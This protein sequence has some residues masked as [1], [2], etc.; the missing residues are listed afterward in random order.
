[1]DPE[2]DRSAG[3]RVRVALEEEIEEN[4]QVIARSDL[5]AL[6]AR[7]RTLLPEEYRDSYE[8]VQ[9]TPMRSAGLKY[10][11]DGQ[12]AWDQIWGGFCDLA[13]AGG[14]PHKGALLEPGTAAEIDAQFSRYD[15]VAEEICR[16]IRMATGLRAYV[17]PDPGW[18]C[19]T[20]HGDAMAGWLMRAI[21][22]ENVAARRRGSILELPAA[23]HFRLD[24]EIKNVITV[25]A[26]TSHYWLGHV[27]DEQQRA[28]GDLFNTMAGESPLIE[29]DPSSERAATRATAATTMAA[30][31]HGSTGLAQSNRRY[32]G[33]LG[34]E[35][36][37]VRLAIW[38]MRALVATNVLSRREGTVLFVP[39][40]PAT[41]PRGAIVA[42]AVARVYASEKSRR[43][44]RPSAPPRR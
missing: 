23:P 16:G 36:G 22:M 43:S 1:L 26:K 17:A 12:V 15:E 19:V 35:C 8:E 7:I 30:R 34:V 9:P 37:S 33:W 27:P 40:N 28:I 38:L 6:D 10:D 3:R 41:D 39:V 25:V 44:V 14:P 24:K 32:D 13:M 20:C 21:V 5:D 18:V 11:A 31:I 4:V 2:R 42:D 29:P